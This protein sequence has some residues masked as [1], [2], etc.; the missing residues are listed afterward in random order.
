M[1]ELTLPSSVD[2]D[3]AP[4]GHHVATIFAQYAPAH[5]AADPAWPALRE[6]MRDRVLA[7]LDE[8]SPGFSESIEHIEVLAAPDLE[9][10]FGLTG[11]NI[12][13]GAMTPDR[14]HVL[15]PLPGW[16]RYR[17]PIEGLYLCGAG[18]HPGGGVMGACGRNAAL[19]IAH[20]LQRARR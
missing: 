7:M 17:T 10:V 12:F 2:P 1:V 4:P 20:D 18:T 6:R 16:A 5:A 11:G 8:V 14:L 3:L 13:H 15:R 9:E 19:E